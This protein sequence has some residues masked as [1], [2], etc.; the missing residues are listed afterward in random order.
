MVRIHETEGASPSHPTIVD[1]AP[2]GIH[3]RNAGWCPHNAEN[4]AIVQEEDAAFATRR[5][6]CESP[7]LHIRGFHVCVYSL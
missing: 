5:L 3:M 6:G 1:V 4:G 2:T 7:W